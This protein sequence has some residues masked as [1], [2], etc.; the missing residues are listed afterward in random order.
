MT[1]L[2]PTEESAADAQFRAEAREFL[3]EHAKPRDP[4]KQRATTLGRTDTSGEA[5]AAHIRECREWQATLA[6]HGWAG[7]TWP[8]E[9]G[10]RGGTP[11]EALIF[12]QEQAKFDVPQSIFAQGIGMA[13]PT[14]IHHG[15]EA[16]KT[17]FLAPMLRGDEVWCQL[18]SEPGAGSDL[19]AL[20]TRAEPDGEE[21]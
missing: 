15:S 14:I 2:V 3:Q 11:P 7:I 4:T 16:Q 20:S 12:S 9:Y 1:Q 13:G 5:E 10:G 8:K 6:A 21:F 18:F 19:A 17:R